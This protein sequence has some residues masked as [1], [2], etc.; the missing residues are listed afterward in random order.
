MK[1]S[2]AEALALA[3]AMGNAALDQCREI[4]NTDKEAIRAQFW[5]SRTFGTRKVAL[6][7]ARIDTARTDDALKS[8]SAPERVAIRDAARSLARN[9]EIIAQCMQ[10]G[11]WPDKTEGDRSHKPHSVTGIAYNV[12]PVTVTDKKF[13]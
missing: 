3:K 6:L 12:S 11:E 10:G 1:P 2:K 5:A 13:H 4:L 7:A 8:F 9:L